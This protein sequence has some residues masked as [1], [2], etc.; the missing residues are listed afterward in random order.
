MLWLTC[1]PFVVATVTNEFT[2]ATSNMQE[3]HW[4]PYSN[5]IHIQ[6]Q[7]ENKALKGTLIGYAFFFARGE[8]RREDPKEK[9]KQEDGY[10]KS[11][12]IKFWAFSPITHCLCLPFLHVHM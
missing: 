2:S 4:S 10:K 9:T 5:L 6:L 3:R 8:V 7:E 12:V 11:I 1:C